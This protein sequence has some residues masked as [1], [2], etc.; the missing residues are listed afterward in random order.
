M[1]SQTTFKFNDPAILYLF[2][3]PAA[4]TISCNKLLFHAIVSLPVSIAKA[5][6]NPLKTIK[7]MLALQA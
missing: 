2:N 1:I 6:A 3:L 5:K 4:A 7:P